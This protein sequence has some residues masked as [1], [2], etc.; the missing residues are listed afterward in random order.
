MGV[1]E[2]LCDFAQVRV[3]GETAREMMAL[4]LLDWSACAI[5]GQDEPAA[6]IVRNMVLGEAG[7]PQASLVGQSQ[8]APVRGAALVNGTASH[9][10]DYDDTHFGHIGHPSVAIVPAALAVGELVGASGAQVLDA[11]L[12]GVEASIRVGLWLGRA[13]YQVGYH[14]T[15]TAGA[16]GATLAAGLLLG[17]D[18]SQMAQSL[19]LVSTRASGLKSQ[20]GTM[21]KPMNAGIAASNGVEAALLAKSGF[22][23]NPQALDGL[24]GFGQ[25]HHGEGD[26]T[27]FDQVGGDWMFE[28][29]SHKFHACCHGLHAMLEAIGK[30]CG[31]VEAGDVA[32]VAITTNPRWENV[33]N[34]SSPQ[35]GLEAKFSYRLTAAMALGGVDTAALGSYSQDVA[36]D[37]V[38]IALRNRVLVCFDKGV[39]ETAARVCVTLK[40]GTSRRGEHDLADQMPMAVRREKLQAKAVALVGS[41][42]AGAIWSAI[43]GGL[44]LPALSAVLRG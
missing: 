40:D 25:T 33:C 9:A 32:S 27:A 7:N 19:G 18:R 23:S 24:Q 3:Y 8:G 10:L 26:L 14:Q 21:G 28:T 15:A 11:A 4:S 29:V 42:R 13:H 38:L 6:K 17:L 36:Q 2:Q 22:V 43:E 41:G 31:D 37:S 35:T 1:S 44:D 34:I 12:I 30:S 39:A 16:F 5:A 20:F